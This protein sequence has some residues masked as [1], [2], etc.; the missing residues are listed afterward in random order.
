MSRVIIL[1]STGLFLL[2]C[3]GLFGPTYP[4]VAYTHWERKGDDR[5]RFTSDSSCILDWNNMAGSP[6]EGTYYEDGD[7]IYVELEPSDNI[8]T[9]KMEFRRTGK[10]SAARIRGYSEEKGWWESSSIWEQSEPRCID[11]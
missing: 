9:L 3:S 10:C 1:G 7:M 5:L 4:S 2:G 8:S 11:L 6:V